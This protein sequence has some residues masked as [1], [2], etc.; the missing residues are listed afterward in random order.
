MEGEYELIKSPL[1]KSVSR[2]GMTVQIEIYRGKSDSGWILEVVDEEGGSTVWSETF[3]TD[4]EAWKEAMRT[5]EQDGIGS[6]LKDPSKK[7]H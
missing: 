1:S 6:F 3:S 5:I 2:D 4:R 7:L